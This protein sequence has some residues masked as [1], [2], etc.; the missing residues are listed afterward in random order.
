MFLH[1]VFCYIHAMETLELKKRVIE[2]IQTQPGYDQIKNESVTVT[3]SESDDFFILAGDNIQ[4]GIS[5]FGE[6]PDLAFDDFVENWERW[7][8]AEWIV[9]NR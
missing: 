9:K 4:E 8:G 5:G 7:K 2:F 3:Y 6:T 1:W